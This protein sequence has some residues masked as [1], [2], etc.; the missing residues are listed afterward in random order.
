MSTISAEQYTQRK[1]DDAVLVELAEGARAFQQLSCT[2]HRLVKLQ[3][4]KLV[5]RAG[6]AKN[7]EGGRKAVLYELTA[8]G[9]KRAEKL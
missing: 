3:E 5:K 7:Q 9:R 1:A 8:R 2:R 6:E 4:Q